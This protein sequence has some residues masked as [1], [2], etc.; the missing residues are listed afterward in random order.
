M[1]EHTL[2]FLLAFDGRVHHLEGGY[3]LEFEIRQV[4]PTPERPH[5]LVYSFTLHDP[6]GKRVVGFDNA[7]RVRTRT[8]N[9]GRLP[10]ADHWHRSAG[11]RGRPYRFI[12][13]AT[14]ID[15]FFDAVE[16][17]LAERGVSTRV[18]DVSE[19]RD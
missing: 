4:E 10:T 19:R 7:H 1:S 6:H 14:L 9:G 17:V 5:G 13:A 15:D 2:A 12:D 11:D 3:W 8:R 18:V 16:A